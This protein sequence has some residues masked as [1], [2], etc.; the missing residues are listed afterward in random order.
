MPV[1][2]FTAAKLVEQKSFLRVR[3][4]RKCPS[5]VHIGSEPD[6]H[7]TLALLRHARVRG[8]HQL[9]NHAGFHLLTSRVVPLQAHELI[10]PIFSAFWYQRWVLKLE[11]N[12]AQVRRERLSCQ[13]SDIF[14]DERGGRV[15]RTARG[16]PLTT[17]S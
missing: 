1:P 15:S 9:M 5:C 6:K 11:E 3:R 17:Y 14:E 8:V 4:L 10:A 2:V 12:V 13:A 16:W 7:N